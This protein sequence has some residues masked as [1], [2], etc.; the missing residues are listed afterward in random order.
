MGCSEQLQT[1]NEMLVSS[2]HLTAQQPPH[3]ESAP[4]DLRSAQ[5]SGPPKG[6]GTRAKKT[7]LQ[8]EASYTAVAKAGVEGASEDPGME[9]KADHLASPAPAHIDSNAA[10]PIRQ[11]EMQIV[12]ELIAS[13]STEMMTQARM[14]GGGGGGGEDGKGSMSAGEDMW[15]AEIREMDRVFQGGDFSS[16]SIE[17]GGVVAVG[18]TETL[19]RKCEQAGTQAGYQTAP[20]R[21]QT[22]TGGETEAGMQVISEQL[23][24]GLG[25]R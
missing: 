22:E 12:A 7:V 2:H 20:P 16:L 15:R 24:R 19:A 14:A 5:A 10:I 3:D 4:Q 11:S 25:A 18:E 13:T 1:L 8:W 6:D 21:A 17:I 23:V 9:S